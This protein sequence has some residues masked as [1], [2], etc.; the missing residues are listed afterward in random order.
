MVKRRFLIP[1]V[2]VL[3]GAVTAAAW[4]SYRSAQPG[5]L[6][7]RFHP[8]VG[9]QALELDQMRYANPGGEG[10][11]KVRDFQFFVSNIR[12][13]S[14]SAEFLE[15][16]SYHLARFDGDDGTFVISIENIPR[17]DY[18]RIEFGIGVD[19]VANGS[20][21]SVGALDPNGRMAW[22]WE[23]GYKFVLFEGAL[24]ASDIHY[25]LVYHVGFDENY[26][27]VSF[28]LGEPLFD[29]LEANID[30]CTDLL[31]MFSG[32]ETVDMTGMSNVKFDRTDAKLLADNYAH[33]VS[34]CSQTP[35]Q[36]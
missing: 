17:E 6:E 18:R 13:V 8:F 36:S 33:M 34:I 2:I 30:F 24:V 3:A 22:N 12:L 28:E 25:P 10:S 27:Q 31:Q 1:A 9:D 5:R 16:E 11:F 21:A 20:L 15:A 26:K 35:K 7:L 23:V 19:P 32:A 29:G 14:S 4:Y